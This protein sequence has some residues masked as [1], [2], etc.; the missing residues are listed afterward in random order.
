MKIDLSRLVQSD[1]A[2]QDFRLEDMPDAI[3]V[4]GELYPLTQTEPFC[5]TIQN[6]GDQ[7]LTV[8]YSGAADVTIPC[9][10]CL[11]P[12]RYPIR[13]EGIRRA[14][15]KRPETERE[16]E[17]FFLTEKELL[18]DL[19]FMDEILLRWPIRVLCKVD[20]KGICSQCGANLNREVCTCDRRVP[21]P[22][23]AAIRDIFN[24]YKEE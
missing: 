14:D 19:L 8:K 23:M 11:E 18:P 10:R 22:R 9:A 3:T 21:D 4:S 17:A 2:R 12:V 13:F 5:I 6:L 24:A 16:E 7:I 20:C 15:L 1:G